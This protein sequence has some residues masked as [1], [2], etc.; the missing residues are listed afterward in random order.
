MNL[1]TPQLAVGSRLDASDPV[2]LE[3]LGIQA[4][5]SLATVAR[6][7]S[8]WCQLQLQ[9][10]DRQPL[11][12]TTIDRAMQFIHAQLQLGRRVLVHCEMGISRS[13]SLVASYLHQYRGLD[14]DQAI[15]AVQ[16]VRPIADPHPELI[17][18]LRHYHQQRLQRLPHG[19]AA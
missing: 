6:P 7:R 10:A 17:R 18:S 2:R 16:A 8:I 4:L 1:V 13:P 12:D 9:M 15:A 19:N 5:L 14:L 11:P 3:E